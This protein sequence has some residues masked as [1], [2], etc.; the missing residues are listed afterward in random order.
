M[1]L[2]LE[3]SSNP[4]DSIGLMSKRLLLEYFLP[5]CY[6]GVMVDILCLLMP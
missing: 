1:R 3:L 4:G 6:A 2:Q 5:A